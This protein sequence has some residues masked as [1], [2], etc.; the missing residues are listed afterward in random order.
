MLHKT[1]G[2]VLKNVRY[3][4]TSCIV[5]VFTELFG[6]QSY[7]VNSVYTN[8]KSGSKAVYFQP[9]SLLDLVVYHNNLKN[10]QRIKEFK[11]SYLYT[12]IAHNVYKNAVALYMIE[13]LQKCL[14]QPEVNA[15]LYHNIENAFLALDKADV[16]QAANYSLY[17]TMALAKWLGFGLNGS[18]SSSNSII[19]L[20]EGK[21]TKNIPNHNYYLDNDLSNIT[22]MLLRVSSL[23]EMGKIQLSKDK[24]RALL[25]AYEG[26]FRY[27]ITDFTSLRSLPVLYM[28]FE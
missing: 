20:M 9:T 27:H 22:Y 17:Y 19:D 4:E 1:K 10:L 5:T 12:S 8:T 3:R 21:F 6:I 16:K 2:I 25:Q 14:K 7:L 13:L 11:F 24:R 26:F 18:Y 15:S 23:E 28:L